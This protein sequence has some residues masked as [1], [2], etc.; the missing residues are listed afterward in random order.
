MGGRNGQLAEWTLINDDWPG[1]A[2]VVSFVRCGVIHLNVEG[3]WGVVDGG[4]KGR[5]KLS[6]VWCGT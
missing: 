4:S 2:Y 5:E 1:A 6:F 3:I